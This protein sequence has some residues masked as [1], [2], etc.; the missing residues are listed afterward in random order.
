MDTDTLEH[1]AQVCWRNV[2]IRHVPP[3]GLDGAAVTA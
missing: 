2:V 1:E 3:G